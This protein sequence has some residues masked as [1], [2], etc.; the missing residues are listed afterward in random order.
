MSAG[1]GDESQVLLS[2]FIDS[3]LPELK[4]MF[5]TLG[6]ATIREEVASVQKESSTAEVDIERVLER[7]T[8]RASQAQNSMAPIDL[9]LSEDPPEAE[10]P[11]QTDVE[12]LT[13]LMSIQDP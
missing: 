4:L 13:A 6:E 10:D 1:L 2:S 7:L 12:V 5:S 11:W 9:T 3:Y 8:E